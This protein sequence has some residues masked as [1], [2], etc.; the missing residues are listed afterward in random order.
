MADT[1]SHIRRTGAFHSLRR[2]GVKTSGAG[3]P[4]GTGRRGLSLPVVGGTSGRGT[5]RREG[6]SDRVEIGLRELG[7]P[8]AKEVEA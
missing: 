2:E 8:G 4:R 3:R 1:F 6:T 7:R 5:T